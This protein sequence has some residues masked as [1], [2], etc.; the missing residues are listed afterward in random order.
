MPSEWPWEVTLPTDAH[1]AKQVTCLI[2]VPPRAGVSR[3][4]EGPYEEKE[5][6]LGVADAPQWWIER[7]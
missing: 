6:R 7:Q 1:Q 2:S 5:P 3:A 4:S